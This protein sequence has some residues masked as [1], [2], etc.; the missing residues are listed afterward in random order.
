[1]SS[2]VLP[3]LKNSPSWSPAMSRAI[4]AL[5]CDNGS[6]YRCCLSCKRFS[7]NSQFHRGKKKSIISVKTIIKTP[8]FKI[9]KYSLIRNH[10]ILIIMPFHFSQGLKYT[11]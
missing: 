6:V 8:I 5:S 3:E 2:Q 11:L 1:M 10:R 4:S 9:K 7:T